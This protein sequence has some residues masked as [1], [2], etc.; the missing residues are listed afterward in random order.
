MVSKIWLW[1]NE[2]IPLKMMLQV[3]LDEEIPGGASFFYTIG[4]AT[5]FVFAI[6]VVTGIWQL[7][8]Y[9][10]TVDHAYNSLNYLRIF[11]PYGWLIHGLH[12]WGGNAMVVLVAL[13]MIRVFIW[14]A[15]KKPREITW[16]IGVFLL[17]LVIGLSFTGAAL[18]WDER[19]YWAAE[20]GTSIA[21]TIPLIGSFLESL[22][23][24]GNFMGQLTLSRFFILHTAIIPGIAMII[25][26]VH[27]T[28]F[29]NFGSIGPW[30]NEKRKTTGAFWPDQVA[31]D[32]IV[33]TLILLLLIALS[34]FN[35]PPFT[36][37]ADPLDT[38]FTPK[39]EWN[40][41]F[42]YETLKFFPGSLEIIGTVG[43]PTAVV[44]LLLLVP[45][46]DR[47]S[48]HNPLKRL[49]MIIGGFVLVVSILILTFIGYYSHPP[50]NQSHA[51]TV[52]NN[53]KKLSI[54][55]VAGKEVFETYGCIAC[56]S[57]SGKGGKIGPDLTN[58]WQ[59]G[60]SKKWI[61]RQLLNSKKNY[62]NSIMPPYTALSEKQISDLVNFLLSRHA[63]NTVLP[64]NPS[65]NADTVLTQKPDEKNKSTSTQVDATQV[66]VKSVKK[67]GLPS[68]AASM[69]GNIAHGDLLFIRNCESCHGIDGKGGISN[70]GSLSGEVPPLNPIDR[71]L[72]N[73]NPQTFANNIDRI[74]QHGSTPPGAP[75]LKMFDYGDSHT[76]TQR[77]ITHLEAYILS[78]NGVNRAQ[79]ETTSF[80]P[81]QYFVVT[82][83]IFAGVSF[84]L[85]FIGLYK[86]K[87]YG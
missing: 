83:T 43:I 27:L 49:P 38:S 57:I 77:E 21:G 52:I 39:P 51:K 23:R 56:H 66:K 1:I 17:F 76:L 37:P 18:P 70:P 25:I 28:A 3:G 78:L 69:I 62:P 31:L 19:G 5:L 33:V 87:K 68:L 7:F 73:K 71:R 63:T 61:I 12:Y 42:L 58:E 85:I 11:V 81:K 41:L 79:I 35:P 74:I 54:S 15:Y 60:R 30:S 84:L 47:R 22:L 13:H 82:V 24:S 6:Q 10:P 29:R 44:L 53:S 32:I 86:K 80:S 46:L 45:F 40:F 2:R 48:E 55:A 72:Y 59:R 65:R 36:G 50:D 9:V 34:A 4:S 16:L 8:Y 75:A 14:G 64:V 20:V 26:A 67:L